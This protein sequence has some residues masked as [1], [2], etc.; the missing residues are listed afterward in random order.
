MVHPPLSW[1]EN[2]PDCPDCRAKIDKKNPPFP[3]P[4]Q[5]WTQTYGSP[6]CFVHHLLPLLP[7]LPGWPPDGG[8]GAAFP[9]EITV[10]RSSAKQPGVVKTRD[11]T[12]TKDWLVIYLLYSS[13]LVTFNM[14]SP[15]FGIWPGTFP[16]FIRHGKNYKASPN[17]S[18]IAGFAR[19][20]H[21]VRIEYVRIATMQ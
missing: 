14:I 16:I 5:R 12:N 18:F 11:I 9:R 4:R 20:K 10:W 8:A 21:R 2:L 13:F 19:K 6:G 1:W 7:L 17:W 15:F 3:A